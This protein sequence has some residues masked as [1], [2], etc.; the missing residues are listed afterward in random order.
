MCNFCVYID[1]KQILRVP[2]YRNLSQQALLNNFGNNSGADGSSAFSN[3]ELESFI[4]SHRCNQFDLDIDVI[5][6]HDHFSAFRQLNNAGNVGRAKIELGSI[7]IKKWR[8]PAA[9]LFGEHIR[10][11]V[12]FCM[13]RNASGFGKNLAALHFFALGPTQEHADIIARLTF[14]EQFAK[15]LDTGRDGFLSRLKADDF[16]FLAYLNYS[17]L[18]PS[19]HDRT[20]PADREDIFHRHQEGLVD[21]PHRLLDERI[22]GL[23]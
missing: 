6:G 5:A 7:A 23:H 21:V 13:R 12:E 9:F 22:D 2:A 14:I 11:G 1:H 4:H 20:A 8:V 16:D 10:L 15:H 19:R 3:S 18:N 17:A